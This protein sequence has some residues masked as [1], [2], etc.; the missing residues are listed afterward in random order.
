VHFPAANN[1][2]RTGR[3]IFRLQELRTIIRL[4]ELRTGREIEFELGYVGY[5]TTGSLR[6]PL[7]HATSIHWMD[8]NYFMYDGMISDGALRF[9]EDGEEPP[10]SM[11]QPKYVMYFRK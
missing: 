11:G 6:N 4:P 7:S 5:G 8:N 2:G 10:A 1:D 9:L 3:P